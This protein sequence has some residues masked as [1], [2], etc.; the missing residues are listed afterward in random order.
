M[1]RIWNVV[2]LHFVNRL[3]YLV[4]PWIILGS[5][6]VITLAIW[7]ILRSVGVTTGVDGQANSAQFSGALFSIFIYLLV[8]AVMAINLTFPFALGFSVTRRDFYLGT[9]LAFAVTSA[10]N[11]VAL[12]VLAA[13][14]Q[15]TGGWGLNGLLFTVLWAGGGTV[16][17]HAFTFFA[18]QLFFCFVG[19]A[20]ATVYMRW[21]IAGM[22]AFWVIGGVA[23]VGGFALATYTASWPAIGAWIAAAGTT[24][25]AAWSLLLSALAGVA[26]YIVLRR[27]TPKN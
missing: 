4:L 11:A 16:A 1:S 12:S 15:A 17:E 20:I 22:V 26:G 2:R 21:R 25:L 10:L 19:A 24:G 3:T 13:I 27:A 6:F 14:E 8:A 5:A 7:W 23:L 18:V 9:A